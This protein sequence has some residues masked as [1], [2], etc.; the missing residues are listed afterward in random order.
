MVNMKESYKFNVKLIEEYM[1]KN[2]YDIEMFAQRCRI[3]TK[4]LKAILENNKHAPLY[5]IIRIADVISV[6]YTKLFIL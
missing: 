4:D 1:N 2:N 3:D 5:A 6:P